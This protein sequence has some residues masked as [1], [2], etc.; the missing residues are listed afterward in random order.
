[1]GAYTYWQYE[2][3]IQWSPDGSQILFSDSHLGAELHAVDTDGSRL[4][5]I[6]DSKVN[7]GHDDRFR[8]KY[9]GIMIHFDV[10]PDGSRIAYSTC[11]YPGNSA[12]S[13]PSYWEYSY[14]IV[15][16]N[17][18]GTDIQ[19]ITRNNHFDNFP[20]WSP[21][22]THIAFISDPD[23]TRDVQEIMGRLVVYTTA[24]GQ[25][26]DLAL[27]IGDRVAPHP[28]T[29]S[30]DG[31]HIAFVAYE[32][33]EYS[34]E[35]VQGEIV[36]RRAVYTV[37]PDGSNLRRISDAFSEPSWS[38]D[39]QR[40]ALAVPGEDSSVDL[41]TFAPDGSD[42]A[43]VTRI[44]E[45][46]ASVWSDEP[47]WLGR[48]SWSPDGSRIMFTGPEA[49]RHYHFNPEDA[50]RVCV[51][52]VDDGLV[53]EASS[54]RLPSFFSE[55]RKPQRIPDVLAWSPDGSR[56]AVRVTANYDGGAFRALVYT[57]AVDGEDPRILV[58]GNLRL[59]PGPADI[60]SCSNG[61]AVPDPEDNPGLVED[62]RTL[63]NIRDTL[64][65]STLLDWRSDTAIME[66]IWVEVRGEP[67]RVHGLEVNG[68]CFE[69][70]IRI[71]F[72]QIPSGLGNLT[73]L[74]TLSL[75]INELSGNI[76]PELGN[77]ANLEHLNLNENLLTGIIPAELG[78]LA[79]LGRLELGYNG[80]SGS[81]PPELGNL[82]NLD[83]LN[84][85][86]NLLTGIIP[87]ELGRLGNLES[88]NLSHNLLTGIIPPELGNLA[89][90][91]Q[92][93]LGGNQLT[94]CIP[95][96]LRDIESHDLYNLGLPYCE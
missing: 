30:P 80:L 35:Y 56:I 75:S 84:L 10:S 59:N 72:G 14:E 31:R 67:L 81:I 39:G 52:T 91:R 24:T 62:C 28:P 36:R 95:S 50:C 6:V 92:L 23:L 89:N 20:A 90:L 42:P 11:R 86:E 49:P 5:K 25:S 93:C 70:C 18:D 32:D 60:E 16:S 3:Y 96:A 83:H 45:W 41:Y 17:I 63:L 55:R 61:V 44:A 9:I 71:L 21:D 37:E 68:L 65:G 33:H 76:P 40:I 58:W 64:G 74:R 53:M 8:S 57:V 94:G 69:G 27:S 47:F 73:D 88:L 48:V 4:H 78:G 7:A 77:L 54:F 66:W 2:D 19:R 29:W 85:N 87:P 15:V 34:D 13:T 1:M 79:S 26:R 82:A 46:V 12:S 38:P 22:G 51:A 43:M